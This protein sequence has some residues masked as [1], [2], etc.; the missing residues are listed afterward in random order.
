MF[1]S[2]Q[3]ILIPALM[4]AQSWCLL[5]WEVVMRG[6]NK[7]LWVEKLMFAILHRWSLRL[8][9]VVALIKVETLYGYF[10][11]NQSRENRYSIDDTTISEL[12]GWS[13]CHST[14][15]DNIG[16]AVTADKYTKKCDVH[17]EILLNLSLFCFFISLLSW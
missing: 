9:N 14:K 7:L 8:G 11:W 6:P 15:L 3:K 1:Q 5:L 17:S 16:H 4:R 12:K 10:W 13:H 2:Y